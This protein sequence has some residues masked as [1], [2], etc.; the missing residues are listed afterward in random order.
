MKPLSKKQLTAPEKF[1]GS[2]AVGD[3]SVVPV[4]ASTVHTVDFI[5]HPNAVLYSDGVTACTVLVIKNFNEET[6][7]YDNVVTMAHF[8]P[9]NAYDVRTAQENI[10]KVMQQFVDK[11]GDLSSPKTSFI[12]FGG[13]DF[14]SRPLD[15]SAKAIVSDAIKEMGIP[16]RHKFTEHNSSIITNPIQ[17]IAVFVDSNGTQITKRN[18]GIRVELETLAE[19]KSSMPL[20]FL[21]NVIYSAPEKYNKFADALAGKVGITSL[22]TNGMELVSMNDVI[23]DHLKSDTPQQRR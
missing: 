1:N 19:A 17:S 22:S 9:N 5:K 8:F 16:N 20:E 11:G 10:Y 7:K 15:S 23:V 12:L 13:Q 2:F 18:L 4:L 3:K 21:Q 14:L 6:K